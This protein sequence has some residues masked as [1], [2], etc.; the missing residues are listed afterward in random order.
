VP[1]HVGGRG[2]VGIGK[3]AYEIAVE[4]GFEGTEAEW[5]AA[6]LQGP[7]ETVEAAVPPVDAETGDIWITEDIDA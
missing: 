4:N 2:N 1:R 3:S 5:I 7:R 6:L